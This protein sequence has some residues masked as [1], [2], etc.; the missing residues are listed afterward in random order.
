MELVLEQTQQGTSYEVL[1][2]AEGVEELKRKVKKKGEKK[3][4][5]LTLRQKLEHQSDTKVIHNDDRNPSRANI[6]QAFGRFNTTVGNPIKEILLKLNLPNHMSILTDSKEFL[7]MDMEFGE[8]DGGGGEFGG[9]SW[10]SM[11]SI[12]VIGERVRMMSME[13]L[14]CVGGGGGTLEGGDIEVATVDGVFE[15][16][17]GALGDK[18]CLEVEALVDG[19]KVYSG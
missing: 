8:I 1:V 16:A 13:P 17:F 7:K 3:E 9:G 5:L 19:M 10:E 6:K 14:S 15:S 2:S 18:T 4:A 12:G 11:C